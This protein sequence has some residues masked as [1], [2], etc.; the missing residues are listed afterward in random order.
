MR[1]ADPALEEVLGSLRVLFE[2]EREIAEEG[3]AIEAKVDRTNAGQAAL[4][5]QLDRLERLLAD[6]T[7][8][9]AELRAR[10]NALEG[11]G[12]DVDQ[13]KD[14]VLRLLARLPLAGLGHGPGPLAPGGEIQ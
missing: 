9:Q 7:A 5:A 8:G 11:A 6:V 10:L 13:L 4:K 12:S 3:R 14:L 1:K 2:A